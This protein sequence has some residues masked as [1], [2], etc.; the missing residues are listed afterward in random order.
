MLTHTICKDEI[1]LE[2]C[3][4]LRKTTTGGNWFMKRN[5]N[6]VP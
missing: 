1:L 3:Y 2:F 5:A 6:C 4:E